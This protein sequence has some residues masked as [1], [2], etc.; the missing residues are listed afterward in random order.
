MPTAVHNGVN[1]RG[2]LKYAYILALPRLNFQEVYGHVCVVREFDVLG[3]PQRVASVGWRQ[4]DGTAIRHTHITIT[5][6][7]KTI[8]ANHMNLQT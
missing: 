5:N 7:N 4:L 6:L 1:V 8:L 2:S 3:V